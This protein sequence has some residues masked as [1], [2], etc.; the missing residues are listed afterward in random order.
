MQSAF[1]LSI[2]I[3]VAA[4]VFVAA[5]LLAQFIT[6][7]SPRAESDAGAAPIGRSLKPREARKLS[8]PRYRRRH[9]TGG[10][11]ARR[12]VRRRAPAGYARTSGK[13]PPR[14]AGSGR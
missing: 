1:L 8:A 7:R 5:Y 9:E 2:V 6:D 14:A 3:A 11:A 10:A 4:F 13:R 12:T